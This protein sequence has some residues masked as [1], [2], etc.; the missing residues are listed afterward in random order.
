M[1]ARNRPPR[2]PALTVRLGSAIELVTQDGDQQTFWGEVDG[3]QM[4]TDPD[5]MDR[6]EGYA[7][8]YLW[9]GDDPE[10]DDDAEPFETMEAAF[11][12]YAEW[13]DRPPTQVD[14]YDVPDQF[15]ATPVGRAIRLD[16]ASD[17]WNDAGQVVE[18]THDF[19]EGDG[20]PPLVYVDSRERPRAFVLVGGDMRITARGID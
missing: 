1:R 11:D 5:A 12:T 6:G 20:S 14:E 15:D 18:Y 16:Y 19:F 10:L 17:K 4:A 2:I 9:K 3:M 7:K 8:L 13:H